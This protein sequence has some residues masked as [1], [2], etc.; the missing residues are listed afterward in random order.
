MGSEHE[1]ERGSVRAYVSANWR[2]LV[3][4]AAAQGLL[5]V[6]LFAYRQGDPMRWAWFG[7]YVVIFGG[8]LLSNHRARRRRQ[9]TVGSEA[10]DTR[11]TPPGV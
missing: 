7:A 3:G 8:A 6:D 1:G 11:A 4:Y 5:A 9:N 10:P 2:Y